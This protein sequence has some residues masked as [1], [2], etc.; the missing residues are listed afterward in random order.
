MTQKK[1]LPPLTPVRYQPNFFTID[2]ASIG[3]KDVRQQLEHPIFSLSKVP[4]TRPRYYDDGRGNKFEVGPHYTGLPTIWDKDLL[5][6]AISQ[7]MERAN[8]DEDISPRIRF[9]TADV[10]EF[11]QRTKGGKEYA[12][13]DRALS[14]L[15][16]ATLKTTIRTDGTETTEGFHIIDRFTIKRQ[17]DRPDGRLIY[18]EFTLSDW[19]YRA[20]KARE[21]LTLHPDYFR[22]RQAL[23]R[24]IYEIARKHCGKQSRWHIS[25]TRLQ[26]KSGSKSPIKLFR[27]KIRQLAA[28]GDLLDYDMSLESGDLVVFRRRQGS[29]VAAMDPNTDRLD[30]SQAAIQKAHEIVGEGIGIVDEAEKEWRAWLKKKGLRPTNPDAMFLSFART[31]ADTRKPPPAPDEDKSEL[32]LRAR[33]APGWWAELPEDA[34]ARWREKVGTR[35]ELENGTGWYRTEEDIARDAFDRQ[36]R[37]L[38]DTRD[39]G[40]WKPPRVMADDIIERTAH[41]DN[42]PEPKVIFKAWREALRRDRRDGGILENN[43]DPLHNFE[44][45]VSCLLSDPSDAPRSHKWAWTILNE[46]SARSDQAVSAAAAPPKKQPTPSPAT[47]HPAELIE[48][49]LDYW[50]RLDEDEKRLARQRHPYLPEE[51]LIR[52]V[53]AESIKEQ[54]AS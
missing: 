22:L 3:I 12:R 52:V 26:Q 33:L 43:T 28:T 46:V 42:C 11:C 37:D 54:Q 31:W 5:I 49:V 47:P 9:H 32:P 21:V 36:Y 34:R 19:L 30:L 14:R 50:V 40:N 38:G 16:G 2:V 35:V 41:I 45:Y 29:L 7:I 8:R 39:F 53:H 15:A 48:E 24:R 27:Q 25:L 20:V 1:L 10:I 51:L 4:D 13:L 18:C 6:F 17:Y 44:T 23:A